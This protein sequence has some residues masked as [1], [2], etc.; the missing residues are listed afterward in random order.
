[1]CGVP[2][3]AVDHFINKLVQAGKRVAICEQEGRR[4]AGKTRRARGHANPQCRHRDGPAA[5]STPRRNHNLAAAFFK[6]GGY[7]FAYHRP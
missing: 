3:H 1:M 6:K 5:C 4:A 7:G 2:F